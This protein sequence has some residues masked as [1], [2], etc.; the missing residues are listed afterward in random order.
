MPSF[1]LTLPLVPFPA[2]P[3]HN[4]ESHDG[5]FPPIHPSKILASTESTRL[6]ESSKTRYRDPLVSQNLS[7]P[8]A[9]VNANLVI[10]SVQSHIIY[11]QFNHTCSHPILN[12]GSSRWLLAL[13]LV[14]VCV[15]VSL[16][17]VSLSTTGRQ[18]LSVCRRFTRLHQL[19]HVYANCHVRLTF[20][21]FF[22]V[23]SRTDRR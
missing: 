3:P 16:L 7:P 2:S 6:R 1:S 19:F 20:T 9:R 11:R 12:K 18:E 14:Q 22:V 5:L 13:L 10:L 8:D 21:P 4:L 23:D 15:G 17:C